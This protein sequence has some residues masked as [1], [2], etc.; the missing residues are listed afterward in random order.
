MND[1]GRFALYGRPPLADPERRAVVRSSVA[2]YRGNTMTAGTSAPYAVRI[3]RRTLGAV[4][5]WER[6]DS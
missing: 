5:F 4:A 3:E 6:M 2:T 1:P